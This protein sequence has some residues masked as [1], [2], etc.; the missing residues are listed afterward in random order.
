MFIVLAAFVATLGHGCPQFSPADHI[1]DAGKMVTVIC[2]DGYGL[3]YD[4]AMREPRWSAEH[5]TAAGVEAALKAKRAGAFHPEA[6]LPKAD[7][8]ELTDYRC[9][10]FDRGHMTPVGDF[11]I[12]SEENDTF[13]LAN[14]VP[15]DPE[16]NEGAWAGIEGAVRKQAQLD[17]ELYIVTGP[18]FGPH[19]TMLKGRVAVPS[20]TWKAVWSPS[21]GWAAAYVAANDASGHWRPATVAELAELIGFDPMPGVSAEVK[22]TAHALPQPLKGNSDLKPR[23]CTAH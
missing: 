13:T 15:Q 4:A 18:G 17:G 8:A 7:R 1:P 2:Y 16:L 21:G 6:L 9:E 20:F 22:A 14:M 12:T 23:T 10:P 3:G 5:L 11:G 19:P